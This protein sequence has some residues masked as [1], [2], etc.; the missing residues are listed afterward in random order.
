MAQWIAVGTTSI[1]VPGL[2]P[3]QDLVEGSDQCLGAALL[4]PRTHA[5]TAILSDPASDGQHRVT[6]EPTCIAC[7]QYTA[8][9]SIGVVIY[10]SL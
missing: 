9:L 6:G 8:P 10:F 7:Q 3:G 1:K 5:H 4:P 2:N